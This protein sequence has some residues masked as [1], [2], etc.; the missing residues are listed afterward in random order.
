M[1]SH[2]AQIALAVITAFSL[3]ACT[4]T[5]PPKLVVSPE[6]A[7]A[8]VFEVD[9][10]TNRYWGKSLSF[11]PFHTEKTRVGE[12]WTWAG[13]IFKTQIGQQ[14]D[15]YRFHFVDDRGEVY[16]V[17]CRAKTPILKRSTEN[18]EWSFPIGETKL[19]CAVQDPAGNVGSLALHGYAG[20]YSGETGFA[21]IA[22][23]EIVAKHEFAGENGRTFRLPSAIGYE[24]RQ[25]GKVVATVDTL[26]HGIVY[27][28][29]E[30]EGRDRSA[31]ALTLT[32]LMFFQEA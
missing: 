15:P 26:G 24:L 32:V 29:R 28:D 17:E 21:D 10:L 9:G 5:A 12:T 11:G 25:N 23:F 8:T 18:S 7:D 27:L 16:K 19:S 2:K 14:T 6:L 4:M 20:D 3:S 30:L 13:G 22:D 1:N 31:A